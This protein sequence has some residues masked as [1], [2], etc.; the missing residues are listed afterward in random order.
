MQA[1]YNTDHACSDHETI[2][3]Q[4]VS[5]DNARTFRVISL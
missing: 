4:T 3:R 2:F 1:K 5:L